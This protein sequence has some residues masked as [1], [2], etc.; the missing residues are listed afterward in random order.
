MFIQH[1]IYSVFQEHTKKFNLKQNFLTFT[2]RIRKFIKTKQINSA[3]YKL[4]KKKVQSELKTIA[5]RIL[6]SEETMDTALL[7]SLTAQLYERVLVLN[8]LEQQ[9][10]R[11]EAALESPS[12]GSSLDSKSYREQNWFNDPKP[13]PQPIYSEEIAEPLI[14]KIKDI[15]AQIPQE[16]QKVD[17]LLNELL[18]KKK[19]S[20]NEL[21]DFASQYHE[22]PV[23]ERKE[24]VEK[25]SETLFKKSSLYERLDQEQNSGINNHH[26]F[27]KHLFNNDQDDFN[28]V[29]SQVDSMSSVK[30]AKAFITD[31][32]KPKYNN[33]KNKNEYEQRFMNLVEKQFS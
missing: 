1:L 27:V 13:V 23:F 22:I 4:M 16:S 11:S 8:Y 31:Q 17:D 21:E 15:V 24:R 14:E 3:I 18:P 19:S 5:K 30:E 7:R 25:D 6:D 28:R 26:D 9:S 29:L 12:A 10:E 32:I 33:W 20:R 2:T